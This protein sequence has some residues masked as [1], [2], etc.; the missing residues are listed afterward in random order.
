MGLSHS[1]LHWG[2]LTLNIVCGFGHC[3]IRYKKDLKLLESVK[4]SVTKM[5]KDLE[6]KPYEEKLSSFD[7]F[8]LERRR[9]LSAV[10]NFFVRGRG[11]ADTDLFSV[12]TSDRIQGN[13]LKLCQER[14]M[15]GDRKRFFTRT[16]AGR[17]SR[18]SKEMVT[19]PSLKE[20]KKCLENTL[21]HM[22]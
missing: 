14:F 12:V 5:V 2:S 7:L 18:L 15:Y 17:W 20:F 22:V 6:G 11:R 16:V 10:S 13:G 8:S 21:R 3:N 1:A 19:A 9:D 4:R